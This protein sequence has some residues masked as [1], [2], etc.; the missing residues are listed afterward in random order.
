MY[1]SCES[2]FFWPNHSRISSV[3][4]THTTKKAPGLKSGWCRIGIAVPWTWLICYNMGK[5]VRYIYGNVSD[6]MEKCKDITRDLARPYS[7]PVSSTTFVFV[8]NEMLNFVDVIS[9]T[10]GILNWNVYLGLVSCFRV[11]Q[12]RMRVMSRQKS[13][14]VDWL[15]FRRQHGHPTSLY[16][17]RKIAFVVRV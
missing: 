7:F 6:V 9:K 1:L 15:V 2:V 11:N 10:C 12:D 13:S 17:F 4:E 8:L 16:P 5:R 14:R 3:R